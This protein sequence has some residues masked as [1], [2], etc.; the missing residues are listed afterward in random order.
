MK[1]H[2]KA[3]SGKNV[4][5]SVIA[6][7]MATKQ[8]LPVKMEA[9]SPKASQ[10][11][12]GHFLLAHHQKT[13]GFFLILV[14][15]LTGW[16]RAA[17]AAPPQQTAAP[18]GQ[19][20]N[21]VYTVQPGDTLL[22]IALKHNLP[23]ANIIVANAIKNPNLIFPGQQL[24][25]SGAF[26]PPAPTTEPVPT[27]TATLAPGVDQ[28][29]VVQPGETLFVIA[30]SYGVSIGAIV[31]A[32]ELAN[33]DVIQAGQT[34]IIP[35]GPLPTPEPLTPPFGSIELSEPV[36]IQGRTLVIKV[37]LV[38][39]AT[40]S[41][42]FEGRPLFFANNG[43][44][45]PWG[46]IAI[47]A[48]TEPNEYPIEIMATRPDQSTTTVYQTVTV[49]NGPYGTENIQL[50]DETSE[51]L[52]AELI[53]MEQEKLVNLWSQVSLRPRWQGSF[54]YPVD[55]TAPRIT[56]Y[57]GTRR[58]YNG[59]PAT[60]FHGG[61]DFGGGNGVPI[62]APA[63]GTVVLAEQLTVRGNAVLIDHG[64][65]LFSGYW[66]NTQLAV[67]EGQQV[68][69]GDLISY[70]GSTGLVTGPHLHWEIRLQGIAVEPLQWIE[71]TIP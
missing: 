53:R 48:L 46:I 63:P 39:T 37:T 17:M 9:A 3:G 44:R 45:Q 54:R 18:E 70:M 43:S 50:D 6:R 29:H 22:L 58:S 57:Y 28:T 16:S 40:V 34:L 42:T 32:N 55:P 19:G 71:D 31:L 56:S 30:S 24:T 36:I 21:F 26:P 8:S 7:S 23:V 64:M 11:H 62:Y 69:A 49:I 60:S 59:G 67:T 41:G 12:E 4:N 14:I 5:D 47:H 20:D 52:D 65:G 13:V 2:Q 38:E 68:Q 25:L 15:L 33:P 27:A 1:R 61:T 10:R 35:A 66:H 51:L